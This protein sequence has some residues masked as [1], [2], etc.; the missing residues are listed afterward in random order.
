LKLLADEN[1]EPQLIRGLLRRTPDL[2]VVSARDAG[3]LGWSDPELL[4][5]AADQGY[6]VITYDVSTMPN[7]AYKRAEQ[8]NPMPG[9]IA[10]RLSAPIGQIVEDL[11][12][13]LGASLPGE[14]EGQVIYL[15]L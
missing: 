4:Q 5:W 1:I 9:V 11:L 14:L 15:P 8:G 13:V 7:F 6:V 10:I 12:I 3:L 2:D